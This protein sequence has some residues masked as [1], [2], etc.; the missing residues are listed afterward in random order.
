MDRA[1]LLEGLKALIPLTL[2]FAL[3][4][5][6]TPQMGDYYFHLCNSPKHDVPCGTMDRG[7]ATSI[8]D[9]S[10]GYPTAVAYAMNFGNSILKDRP[11]TIF[12]IQL[13]AAVIFP[14]FLITYIVGKSRPDWRFKAGF[15]YLY[16]SG[17]PFILMQEWFIPQAF[18]QVLML[19]SVAEPP[20]LILFLMLG[21]KIHREWLAAFAS[22]KVAKKKE[23]VEWMEV[24][25][26]FIK[27]A[28]KAGKGIDFSV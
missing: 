6:F 20:A 26:T 27:T 14:Y 4:Y 19:A 17:V 23:Y 2:I 7:D 5:T 9:A 22:S 25:R 10:M 3:L 15:V 18:I 12:L 13:M 8:N 21:W 16:G 1:F 11:L 24:F 28:K